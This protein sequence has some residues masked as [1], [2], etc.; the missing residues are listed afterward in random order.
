MQQTKIGRF[1]L[2]VV[3]PLLASLAVA[4]SF[5]YP[6][7]YR[8]TYSK[9]FSQLKH[10]LNHEQSLVRLGV[11]FVDTSTGFPCDIDKAWME[12]PKHYAPLSVSPSGE[13]NLPLD[14]NL[15]QANPLVYVHLEQPVQC[16]F[17]M[18]V[19]SREPLFEEVS[20]QQLVLIRDDMQSMQ[21]SL[22]G[23]FARWFTPNI[24]GVTLE[25][26]QP[27]GVI[28]LDNGQQLP[29][30]N[31]RASIDLRELDASTKLSLPAETLRVMPFIPDG[32][33]EI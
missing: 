20:H 33:G 2:R 30:Q 21:A 10:N 12:N 8:F 28:T 14:S 31:H 16:D 5:A 24:E 17:S 15:R 1:G 18:V 22:G 11:F 6:Q 23:M 29:V 25:F 13:L 4:S 19:V 26:S 27:Q 7:E 32:R 3:T 9:L